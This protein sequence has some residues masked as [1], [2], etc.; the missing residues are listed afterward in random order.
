MPLHAIG[1]V[2]ASVQELARG[3]GE[4]VCLS[5]RCPVPRLRCGLASVVAMR[6]IAGTRKQPATPIFSG[7]P[8]SGAAATPGNAAVRRAGDLQSGDEGARRQARPGFAPRRVRASGR[9][10]GRCDGVGA[11]AGTLRVPASAG[12]ATPRLQ[13]ACIYVAPPLSP[14][15]FPADTKVTHPFS[16]GSHLYAP[17]APRYFAF[18]GV[19]LEGNGTDSGARHTRARGG[20]A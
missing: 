1:A 13:P 4:D 11:L 19:V 12:A 16:Y 17:A 2:A 7:A 8:A 14:C 6:E 10:Q 3:A 18:I 15:F 5:H 9:R 20:L